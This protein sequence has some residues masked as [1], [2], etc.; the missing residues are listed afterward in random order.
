MELAGGGVVAEEGWAGGVERVGLDVL[1]EVGRGDGAD[2]VVARLED[3]AGSSTTW[4]AAG[5]WFARS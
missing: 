3:F 5:G 4:D 1:V 2:P